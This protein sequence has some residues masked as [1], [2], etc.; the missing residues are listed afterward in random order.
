MITS[1]EEYLAFLSSIS[2]STPKVLQ[3]R[4]PT[5]EPIYSVDLNSRS[6]SAPPFIGVAGDHEAEI[7]FFE[8]DRFYDYIDLSDTLGLISF[9]NAKKEEFWYIIPF[10]DIT[11]V[12]GKMIF[13]WVIQAPAALYGGTVTFAIKF[14]KINPLTHK[15]LFELN[16]TQ[17]TT[18]VLVGWSDQITSST[19]TYNTLDPEQVLVDNDLIN[20]LNSILEAADYLQLYWIDLGS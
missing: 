9:T 20:K 3:M 18:K 7:I 11:S 10:Y 8:V 16:T 6:I 5:T 14:F 19:H 1:N 17:A 12:R 13:P 4:L 15:L 2:E